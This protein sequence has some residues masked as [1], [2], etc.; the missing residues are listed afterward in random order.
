MVSFIN[1]HNINWFERN[2]KS[3]HIN[4][5]PHKDNNEF[6]VSVKLLNNKFRPFGNGGNRRDQLQDIDDAPVQQ[7][8]AQTTVLAI[9][10]PPII[11]RKKTTEYTPGW[12][13]LI[14]KI[15]SSN[16]NGLVALSP[17]RSVE[18]PWS[19]LIAQLTTTT[20][21]TPR[22][23]FTP[24]SVHQEISTYSTFFFIAI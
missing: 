23:K 5:S 1:K 4:D 8:L 7:K 11:S 20:Y 10:N 2:L 13:N 24:A 21:A 15:V 3:T 14:N 19:T 9:T 22:M 18:K 12:D 16:K 6:S 17:I